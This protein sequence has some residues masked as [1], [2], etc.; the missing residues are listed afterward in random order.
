[1]VRNNQ[2]LMQRVKSSEQIISMIM[3]ILVVL[4]IGGLAYRYFQSKGLPSLPSREQ[5]QEQQQQEEEGETVEMGLPT[6]HT[7]S[8]GENLWRIAEQYYLSGYNWVDIVE[9]ND[10]ANPNQLA[11]GQELTIPDVESKMITVSELPETGADRFEIS[12]DSYTVEE[13]DS[14]S[15]IALRA[16]GDMFSWPRIWQA[17]RGQ[18]SNPNIIEPGMTLEIPRE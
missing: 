2:G 1:M 9:A 14:L 4:A 17:N 11:V 13:G 10:L 18:I 5:E 16:Y 15:K 3:G 8:E 12:G 7:V 6:T